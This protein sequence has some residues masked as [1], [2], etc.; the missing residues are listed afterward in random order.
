MMTDK[1]ETKIFY[2]W[3]LLIS[4]W[5]LTACSTGMFINSMTQFQ[6]PVCEAMN[7][8]RGQFSLSTSFISLAVMAL[9][10]FVGSIFEKFKPKR[11]VT[12]GGILMLIGWLGFSFVPNI[13]LFY[14]M[15]I[16]IGIGSSVAGAVVVNIILNNWFHAKKG[17][18]MGFASTGSGFGSMVF[19]P[20]G[21]VL[22]LHFGYQTAFRGLWICALLCILPI[23]I[24]FVYKPEEKGLLPYGDEKKA[25]NEESTKADLA[26]VQ[27]EGYTRTQALHTPA[28]WGVCFI[29]FGLS[30]GAIGIFSQ[31]A[32]YLTDIGHSPALAATLVSLISLSMAVSKIFFGWLNDKLGTYR[33]FLIIAAI[34]IFGIFSLFTAKNVVCA[35]VSAVLFGISFSATNVM[36]P[37][38]TVYAMGS[39]D[40]ANIFGLV[41]FAIYI[42]PIVASPFSAT[43]YDLNGSYNLAF[44]CYGILYIAVFL[45]G[46]VI[47]KKGFAEKMNS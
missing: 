2:G 14:V 16:L 7:I 38:I 44:L 17:F 27:T 8:T 5:L 9:S 20:L 45:V 28:F 4:A 41:S 19:N 25:S 13:Q 32:S 36:A 34:G 43:I 18:A 3:L 46:L 24:L 6:K 37:L 1:K 35:Y 23:L 15:A 33:N 31:M 42:G 21:S 26:A 30:A 11:V 12:L 10:P 29:S 22:I 40:F 39:K 47:L